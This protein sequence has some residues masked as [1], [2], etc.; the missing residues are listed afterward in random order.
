[1]TWE[2]ACEASAVQ[3][4]RCVGMEIAGQYIALF[5]VEGRFYATSDL[6]THQ[7]ALLSAGRV[8]GEYIECP[9]HQGRFH[10]PTGAP[11]GEPVTEPIKVYP[12]RNEGGRLLLEVDAADAST[13]KLFGD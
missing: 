9:L 7:I 3:P 6:C 2:F 11:Q 4:G 13:D 1:M 8:D 5:N 10:I 12:I